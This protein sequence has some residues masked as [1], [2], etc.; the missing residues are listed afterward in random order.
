MDWTQR[1]LKIY[2]VYVPLPGVCET[3]IIPSVIPPKL[4][5]MSLIYMTQKM[6]PCILRTIV[7]LNPGT[8]LLVGR[9]GFVLDSATKKMFSKSFLTSAFGKWMISL[10]R[11][12]M[13][14]IK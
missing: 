4:S 11:G 5:L 8:I 12:Y 10:P 14:K 9:L 2:I 7:L 1:I 13:H 3:R 6:Q